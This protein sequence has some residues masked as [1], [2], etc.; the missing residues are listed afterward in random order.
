MKNSE[1]NR[2][3]LLISS[4]FLPFLNSC[5]RDPAA[6]LI[7][8]NV[9]QIE[10]QAINGEKFMLAQLNKPAVFHFFG[11]W[12]PTCM[13]DRS[14]WELALKELNKVKEIDVLTFHV[15]PIP[16]QYAS[17]EKWQ[18]GLDKDVITPLIYDE[19]KIVFNTMKIPGTPSTLLIDSGGRIIEHQWNFKSKRAVR[20]FLIKIKEVFGIK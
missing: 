2:R 17:L 4:A 20:A 15:G 19:K 12:C 13:K 7:G 5:S 6:K 14:L 1:I 8:Q 11:L 10:V 16:A 9:P 18:S 3:N